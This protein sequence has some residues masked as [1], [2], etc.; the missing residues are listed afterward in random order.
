MT[1]RSKGTRAGFTLIELSFAIAFIS[2]L[3]ITITLITNEI[4]SIYRKGYSIKTVNQV[5]RDIIDDFQ[6]SITQ[7]PPA[8][9]SSF[10]SRAYTGVNSSCEAD[11]GF[12]SVY[13]QYYAE[14]KFNID[15]TERYI[16]TGGLFCSGKYTY[17]WNTGYLFNRDGSYNFGSTTPESLRI[18]LEYSVNGED[19]DHAKF[20][21]GNFRLLKIED[22]SRSICAATLK[23][24]YPSSSEILTVPNKITFTETLASA[25][26]EMLKDTDAA[27]ALY[28]FVLFEP[29]RVATTGRLLFSGSFI[30]GTITGGVDIM[31]SSNYCKAPSNFSADFSYCAINKF[32]F[33]I[34]ASGNK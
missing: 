29:A 9:I 21:S 16:P 22:S 7:S 8:S 27:L 3:L 24:R 34:Q 28:D 1:L 20:A 18:K 5:G 6:N 19:P 10:C 17:I 26:E 30:L 32:N 14:I 11:G 4:V 23:D 12:Y 13:Q 15:N 25:P 31:T 33:S 2:V